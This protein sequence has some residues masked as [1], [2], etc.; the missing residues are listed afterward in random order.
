M[1]Q[2]SQAQS[3]AKRAFRVQGAHLG[4]RVLRDRRLALSL[5]DHAEGSRVDED[6]ARERARLDVCDGTPRHGAPGRSPHL[7]C[8]RLCLL[9][10]PA[11]PTASGLASGFAGRRHAVNAMDAWPKP[12]ETSAAS[13][14][15]AWRG[16]SFESNRCRC[17]FGMNCR[18]MR[19]ESQCDSHCNAT[20]RAGRKY[21]R[22]CS[23]PLVPRGMLHHTTCCSYRAGVPAIAGRSLMSSHQGLELLPA[24]C[25]TAC[26][27]RCTLLTFTSSSES[28][29][30]PS[31]HDGCAS[32]HGS[33]RERP[34]STARPQDHRCLP[35]QWCIPLLLW[36]AYR[37]TALHQRRTAEVAEVAADCCGR[38]T[39][40]HAA[41]RETGGG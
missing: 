1:E 17:E 24:S 6:V 19:C 5:A 20:V 11:R 3:V 26:M 16:S 37:R 32:V 2:W 10:T 29:I 7:V 13:I 34:S 15:T 30:P 38:W 27:S 40:R 14:G 21:C 41:R 35:L 28:N 31:D 8:Q 4:Q 23:G 39:G 25:A 18:S 9:G 36:P 12:T 33:E 22:S